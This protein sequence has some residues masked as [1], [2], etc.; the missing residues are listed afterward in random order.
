MTI[1]KGKTYKHPDIKTPY[2][3]LEFDI[4]SGKKIWTMV[5]AIAMLK[6]CM[7][8]YELDFTDYW[9]VSEDYAEKNGMK[10]YDLK[11]LKVDENFNIIEVQL[12]NSLELVIIVM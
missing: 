5:S 9:L 6:H 7:N 8:T 3:A 10:E 4:K 11:N 2:T 1:E 12:P